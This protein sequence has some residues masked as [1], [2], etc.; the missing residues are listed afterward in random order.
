MAIQDITKIPTI[1]TVSITI[2]IN[3][4]IGYLVYGNVFDLPTIGFAAIIMLG[5]TYL[6]RDKFNQNHIT[7]HLIIGVIS[8]GTYIA[9]MVFLKITQTAPVLGEEIASTLIFGAICA[10]TYWVMEKNGM[11]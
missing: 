9:T 8:Y 3:I 5:T 6:L 1:K 2:I 10:G 7:S 4:V 11:G